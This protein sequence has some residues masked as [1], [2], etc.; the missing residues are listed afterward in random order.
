MKLDEGA[1]TVLFGEYGLRIELADKKAGIT[2]AFIHIN[3]ENL[4]KALGRLAYTPADVELK[5][6]DKVGKKQ[7][8]REFIFE[9]SSDIVSWGKDRKVLLGKIAKEK[10][11]EGWEADM[12]FESQDSIFEKDGKTFVRTTIRRWV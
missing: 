6:L 4:G 10:C 11:P 12:Y 2:F 7:E 3:Q 5:W 1:V 8:H 9:V